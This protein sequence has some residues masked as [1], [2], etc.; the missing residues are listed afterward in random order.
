M[1]FKIKRSWFGDSRMHSA[2]FTILKDDPPK[3]RSVDMQKMM[4]SESDRL[5]EL[6]YKKHLDMWQ[7]RHIELEA[8]G[9]KCPKCSVP[10]IIKKIN[11]IFCHFEYYQPDCTCYP[12]CPFCGYYLMYEIEVNIPVCT[13]CNHYKFCD[14]IV[15]ETVT[16]AGKTGTKK[17][18]CQGKMLLAKEGYVCEKCN[19]KVNGFIMHDDLIVPDI[20]KGKSATQSSDPGGD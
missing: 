3:N 2:L 19:H 20:Y 5:A 8:K 1:I 18:K 15:T 17:R 6:V 9:G 12:V 10:W 11:N 4:G 14:Q 16:K 7:L 13:N